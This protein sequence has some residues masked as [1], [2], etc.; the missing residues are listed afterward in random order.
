MSLIDMRH[1]ILNIVGPV[2]SVEA[3]VLD[4]G[5]IMDFSDAFAV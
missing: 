2:C 4:I 5:Y 3:V 1:A